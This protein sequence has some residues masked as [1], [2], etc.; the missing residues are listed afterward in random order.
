MTQSEIQAFFPYHRIHFG[1]MD[2]TVPD[3]DWLRGP[4]YDAFKTRYWS[5]NLDKWTVRWQ[6]R[7]FTR[8]FAVFAGE[9]WAASTKVDLPTEAVS[10]GEIWFRPD[11][12]KPA[13][14]AVNPVI[15]DKGLVFL[16]PQNNSLWP[17]QPAQLSSQYFL[18]F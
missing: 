15:C 5:S 14:H 12:A 6:C 2:Y 18:R 9:C 11:P 1:A 17:M 3:L 7:D 4:C 13:G 10:V 8:A 16:E